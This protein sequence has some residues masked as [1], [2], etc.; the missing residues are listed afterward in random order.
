MSYVPYNEFD[1][2]HEFQPDDQVVVQ[3]LKV[4]PRKRYGHFVSYVNDHEASIVFDA[5]GATNVVP[6]SV[7]RP[8]TEFKPG[9]SVMF[10][11]PH[12]H[13]WDQGEVVRHCECCDMVQVKSTANFV[14]VVPSTKVEA[15]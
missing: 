1:L 2:K 10:E 11:N 15:T 4:G 6:L 14:Y 8:L 7:V 12:S 5:D 9:E 3:Y 13:N